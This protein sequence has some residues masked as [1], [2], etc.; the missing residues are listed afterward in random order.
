MKNILL[1]FAFVAFFICC[2][3]EMNLTQLPPPPPPVE[4]PIGGGLGS[5]STPLNL[6][7]YRA[8]A[9]SDLNRSFNNNDVYIYRMADHLVVNYELLMRK[10]AAK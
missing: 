9:V 10:Q 3:E 6:T 1:T 5:G 4:N 8:L 2:T 7:A